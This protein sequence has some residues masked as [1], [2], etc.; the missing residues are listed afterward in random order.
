MESLTLH[1]IYSDTAVSTNGSRVLI[2]FL[3]RTIDLFFK[4]NG[5]KKAL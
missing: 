5:I 4:K 2:M 1:C 3:K